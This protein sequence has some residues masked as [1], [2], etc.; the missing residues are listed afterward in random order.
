[1]VDT[2]PENKVHGASMGPIWVLSA[3]DGSHVGPMNFAIREY[4]KIIIFPGGY[5]EAI[6]LSV[7]NTSR[8]PHML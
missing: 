5:N 3:P 1:M 4:N 2:N 6:A 7:L 8:Y